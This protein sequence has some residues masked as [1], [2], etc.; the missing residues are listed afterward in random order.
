MRVFRVS[1]NAGSWRP[2]SNC[3]LDENLM[4]VSLTGAQA[5]KQAFHLAAVVA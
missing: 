2:K 4:P 3:A 1:E 5:D